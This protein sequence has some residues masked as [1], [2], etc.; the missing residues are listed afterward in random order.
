[1]SKLTKK[2]EKTFWMYLERMT[3]SARAETIDFMGFLL[4]K[5]E[6]EDEATKEIMSDPKMMTGIKRGLAQYKRGGV[7]KVE[8]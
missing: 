3:P 8:L 2:E 1:M 5:E 7:S 4:S 6:T